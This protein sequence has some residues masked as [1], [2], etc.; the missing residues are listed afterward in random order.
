MISKIYNYWQILRGNL[1]FVPA[2]ISIAYLIFT[3]GLY[4]IE[5]WYLQDIGMS[6]ILFG[7]SAEDA[8]SLTI[9]LLS[10][11]ITTATL[12][13]SITMVV[14]SLAASQLG[15]RLIRT[16]MSDQWT[17]LFIGMFFG[18]IIACFALAMILHDADLGAYTPRL[19]ITL[20]FVISFTNMFVLLGF[21]HHVAQSSIADRVIRRVSEDLNNS[22]GRLTKDKDEEEENSIVDGSDWPKDFDHKDQAIHFDR[23]GYIQHINYGEILEIAEEEGLYV[24]I[25]FHAGHFLIEGENGV[26]VYPRHK[27]S[28]EI[29]KK[30]RG[31]FIIGNTP[32]PTQ[33]IEYSIRHLVEIALRALS[34]GINDNFT[35]ISVLD[36]LSAAMAILFRKKTPAEWRCDSHGRVRIWGKQ[37]DDA[38]IIFSAF[39]QIRHNAREKPD[40]IFHI[41]KKLKTLSTLARTDR[42]K[43]GLKEQ[44]VQIR[45]DLK[46][47]ET[48]VLDV[49]YMRNMCDS[50][51]EPEDPASD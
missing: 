3:M 8:K 14:L 28:N 6:A 15:P 39:D 29:A 40:I 18:A 4:Y 45:Y 13:I 37:A 20:V 31:G 12:A 2:L 26:R 48:T 5:S 17:K 23:S 25:E 9:T 43:E 33:D 21:V 27:V 51:I 47:L 49:N 46:H 41:L 38:D 36:R 11:M 1:W 42:Q 19:T 30:I 10:S 35:A 24:H 50:M 22:L 32:T 44:L 34:P 16:F 7:G